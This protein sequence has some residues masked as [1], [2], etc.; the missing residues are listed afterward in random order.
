[1]EPL[2]PLRR[3][4]APQHLQR[5]AGRQLG[6]HR[7][8]LFRGAAQGKAAGGQERFTTLS[9]AHLQWTAFSTT[10]GQ[11]SGGDQSEAEHGDRLQRAEAW[12]QMSS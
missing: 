1:M 5:L 3:P 4:P 11:R 2:P 8:L 7:R 6:E 9:A 10:R 12:H